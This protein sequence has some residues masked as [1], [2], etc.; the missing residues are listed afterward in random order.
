M[1]EIKREIVTKLAER[2]TFLLLVCLKSPAF[3]FSPV[4]WVGA[5]L[6]ASVVYMASGI[7]HSRVK[8]VAVLLNSFLRKI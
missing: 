7:W 4:G 5:L 6:F 2:L 8:E 1:M 3:I